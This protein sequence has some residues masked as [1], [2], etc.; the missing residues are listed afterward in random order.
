MSRRSVELLADG[1]AIEE[2]YL[3]TDKQ[4]RTNRQGNPF[5]QLELRDKTGAISA[6]MWNAN[7][8][9]FRAFEEGD[10]LRIKGKVQLYQGSLQ[11][12]FTAFERVDKA[13]VTLAEFMPQSE[14]DIGR[15]YERLRSILLKVDDMH[16]RALVEC[17]L[18]DEAFVRDFCRAPAGIRNHHA[19]VGGL[20]EHVVHLLEAADRLLP[21]Y[22]ELNRDLLLMGV[23]LHDV[24]KV[25]ELSFERV[26]GYT[27]EGQLVGHIVI[28]VEMLDE[29]VA[30]VPGL[31]G[32]PF[33]KEL[34]LR[35]KHMILSHHGAYEFG[36]PRLPMTP[37]AIALHHL[38]NLDAKVHSFTRDIRDD[39]QGP[40]A[41]TPYNHSL[42]RRL[43][44][45]VKEGAEPVTD[46][47]ES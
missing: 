14:H 45:G 38:D 30:Q 24:G 46:G 8:H 32:E 20:L 12:L 21:L 43:F 47:G 44:K 42:Q 23:F 34:L 25:R 26:F 5:L 3:V 10:F 37:E 27:D 28:G 35:L 15:M 18:M 40:S 1:E 6:R 29:K 7:E 36:S 22:T 13:H 31:T 19:Y 9:L 4:L 33:P 17:F 16:L 39:R 41:W 11:I 2:V